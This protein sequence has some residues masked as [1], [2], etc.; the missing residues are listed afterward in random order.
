MPEG[1]YLLSSINPQ[2]MMC[3]LSLISKIELKS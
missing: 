3:V 2:L 1:R